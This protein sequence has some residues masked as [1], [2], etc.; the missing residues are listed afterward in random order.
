MHNSSSSYLAP[1]TYSH[2]FT[3]V[4]QRTKALY[5]G[6]LL[7]ADARPQ[8]S[9]CQFD[10]LRN[11]YFGLQAMSCV[12]H[13]EVWVPSLLRQLR[14]RI[15]WPGA[16]GVAPLCVEMLCRARLAMLGI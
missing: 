16:S 1:R 4:F 7:P 11:A 10:T 14:L 5:K 2:T 9:L 13:D 15:G 8:I 12:L 6:S 3:P